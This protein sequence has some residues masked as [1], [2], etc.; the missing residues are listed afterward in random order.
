MQLSASRTSSHFRHSRF[1]D[2]IP[3]TWTWCDAP[4]VN[5]ENFTSW[6]DIENSPDNF[7]RTLKKKNCTHLSKL[8]VLHIKLSLLHVRI[9]PPPKKRRNVDSPPRKATSSTKIRFLFNYFVN[10]YNCPL[11]PPKSNFPAFFFFFFFFSFFFIFARKPLKRRCQNS[12]SE[13]SCWEDKRSKQTPSGSDETLGCP[14][15]DGGSS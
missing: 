8:L 13:T 15:D 7:V 10:G 2:I 9:H 5:T 14:S 6:N 3:H 4:F 1:Y 11:T 12:V